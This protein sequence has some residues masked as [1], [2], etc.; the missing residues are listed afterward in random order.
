[1][2]KGLGRA[3]VE[4]RARMR[5]SQPDLAQNISRHG[6]VCGVM[7]APGQGAISRWE[8]GTQAPSPIYRAAM[9]RL[10]AKHGH[11][12]LVDTFRAPMSAW[13]LVA[14]VDKLAGVDK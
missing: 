4:L 7:A 2:Q 8:N 12:D 1:M 13:R 9:A 6:G 5:W 3:V 14:H 10:A 11:N